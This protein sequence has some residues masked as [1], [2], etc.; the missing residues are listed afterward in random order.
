MKNIDEQIEELMKKT[1]ATTYVELAKILDTTAGTIQ[2]WKTRKKI[3]D[4]VLRRVD[5]IF[6]I[7]AAMPNYK[8]SSVPF[9]DVEASCGAG[10]LVPAEKE[11]PTAVFSKDFVTHVLG[12]SIETMYT[13]TSIGH[14]MEPTI[15]RNAILAVQR[16][17]EFSS[18][19]VYL[20][21]FDGKL[22][23]KRLQYIKGGLRVLSDNPAFDTWEISNDEMGAYNFAI[24]GEVKGVAQK[25]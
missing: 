3:P 6:P 5:N 19:G 13:I 8:A 14:S 11:T 16:V 15:Q 2:G 17:E 20:F 9:Y 25:I 12:F 1:Q 18:D 24:L 10:T 21:K 7:S 4:R 23:V 22:L